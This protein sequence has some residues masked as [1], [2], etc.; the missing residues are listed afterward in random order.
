[1]KLSPILVFVVSCVLLALGIHVHGLIQFEQGKKAERATWQQRENAELIAANARI[2][3]LTA[4]ARRAEQA[5]ASAL[6]KASSTYQEQLQHEKTRHDRA[7]A[8]VQSGALR[9]RIELARRETAGGGATT[10]GGSSAGRCD[11]ETHGELSPAAAGFLI[12]LASEAD[13][14]VHQLT[15][16]QT[17][18]K[19]C[20]D[21]THREQ[22]K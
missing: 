4:A 19:A 16:A 9:L 11:G 13:A 12:G 21:L 6:A 3:E 5:H 18:I 17:I 8:D 22:E 14:V 2:L 15:A 20:E 10:E 7:I 1:M